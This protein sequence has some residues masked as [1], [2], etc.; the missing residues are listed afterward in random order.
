MKLS[1]TKYDLWNAL[2][3]C[4]KMHK[5]EEIKELEKKLNDSMAKDYRVVVDIVEE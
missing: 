1:V 2:F 4:P 5:T 3:S